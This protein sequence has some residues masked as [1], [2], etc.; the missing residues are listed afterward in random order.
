MIV[1][2]LAVGVALLVTLGAFLFMSERPATSPRPS[3]AAA[4]A[5]TLARI[6]SDA[7]ESSPTALSNSWRV[8]EANSA[9]NV[10]VVEV[11]AER[12]EDARE[13]AEEVVEPVRSRGYLEVLVYIRPA[14]GG[15]EAA[16][17]R[18]QWTPEGGFVETIYE[19][20]R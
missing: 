20:S 13:I 10:L 9:H 8:I 1:R 17:R 11:E 15:D 19:A 14:G 12:L 4:S 3:S 18:V 2:L 6:L 5:S 16:M 7:R